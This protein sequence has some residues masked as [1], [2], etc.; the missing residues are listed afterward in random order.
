M[1]PA[2]PVDLEDSLTQTWVVIG[3][4]LNDHRAK[5]LLARPHGHPWRIPGRF[6]VVCE[7]DKVGYWCRGT[8]RFKCSQSYLTALYTL[9]CC[10][11]A[12]FKLCGDKPII[13]IAGGVASFGKRGIVPRLLQFQLQDASLFAL[14]FH[15]PALGLKCRL[16]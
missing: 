1:L 3:D 13:R 9:Q 14:S 4:D 5:K 11:P 6:E 2:T 7:P 15:M 12:F 8:G 10:F 16:N